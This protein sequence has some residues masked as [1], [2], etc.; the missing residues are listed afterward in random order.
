VR[1]DL[2]LRLRCYCPVAVLIAVCVVS[3]SL[4]FRCWLL[5]PFVCLPRCCYVCLRCCS[6]H[7]TVTVRWCV[8]LTVVVTFVVERCCCYPFP[9]CCCRLIVTRAILRYAMVPLLRYCTFVPFV[10]VTRYCGCCALPLLL[11]VLPVFDV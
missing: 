2:L 6:L 9:F 8:A 4:P 11:I 1:F 10:V 3:C 7:Y 5:L